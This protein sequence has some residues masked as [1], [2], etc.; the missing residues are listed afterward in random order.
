MP[1]LELVPRSDA[2]LWTAG[3]TRSEVL[4]EYL[5]FIE[6]LKGDQAGKLKLKDG[7]TALA[8]RQRLGDAARLAGKELV[9]R[10]DGDTTYFWLKPSAKRR[11]RPRKRPV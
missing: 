2:M 8:V 6:R 4:R 7:K 5:D 9:I 11:G 1:L 3:K 10:R